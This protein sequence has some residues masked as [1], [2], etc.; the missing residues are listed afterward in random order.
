MGYISPI[1][2]GSV[3]LLAFDIDG[4]RLLYDIFSSIFNSQL[5]ILNF[6]CIFVVN[7]IRNKH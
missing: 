5:S 1:R 7:K 6:I 4:R 3:G 2:L